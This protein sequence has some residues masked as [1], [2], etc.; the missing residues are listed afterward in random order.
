METD[1]EEGVEWVDARE[2]ED[3][4]LDPYFELIA[5]EFEVIAPTG[6]PCHRIEDAY[7]C[8]SV[9]PLGCPQ[10]LHPTLAMRITDLAAG[11]GFDVTPIIKNEEGDAVQA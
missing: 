6:E 9:T 7:C 4:D 3:A 2:E 5:T 8:G 11:V 10:P 1:D